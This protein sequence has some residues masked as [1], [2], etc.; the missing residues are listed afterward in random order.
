LPKALKETAMSNVDEIK[1]AIESLPPAD[2]SSLRQWFDERDWDRWDRQI[3]ADSRSG[4]LDFLIEEA[5]AEKANG[6]LRDL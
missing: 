5:R 3:E 2:Y 4:K 1:A 6:S